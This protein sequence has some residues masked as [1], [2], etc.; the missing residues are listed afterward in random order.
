VRTDNT[1]TAPPPDKAA[2]NAGKFLAQ[3]EELIAPWRR[4]ADALISVVAMA[5]DLTPADLMS[6]SKARKVMLAKR[7]VFAVAL[8]C[9]APLKPETIGLFLNL[10]RSAAYRLLADVKARES[11]DEDYARHLDSLR[12]LACEA[13]RL[14]DGSPSPQ[15]SNSNFF[16]EASPAAPGEGEN[17]TEE[18]SNG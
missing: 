15:P 18:T 4:R 13:I 6:G 1:L 17:T 8:D 2:G 12:A 11:R 5:H 10:S 9:L 3:A 16:A 7:E 14:S